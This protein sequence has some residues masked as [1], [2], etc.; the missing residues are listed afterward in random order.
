MQRPA[1]VAEA[2]EPD[3]GVA[4][5]DGVGIAVPEVAL[6]PL[7]E[8]TV[9]S[10]DAPRQV[11]GQAERVLGHRLR[12]GRAAAQDADALAEARRIV[13]VGIEVALDVDDGPQLGRAG[14]PLARQ[15]RLSDDRKRL[16]EEVVE[17]RVRLV[18]LEVV[19]GEAVVQAGE[20]LLGEDALGPLRLGPQHDHRLAG[21]V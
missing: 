3:V 20:R 13:H 1:E 9:L 6:P 2:D 10:A 21:G 15:V 14:Y 17:A 16:G 11:E 12:V 19:D 5:Q 8:R 4:Q 7:A 18:P